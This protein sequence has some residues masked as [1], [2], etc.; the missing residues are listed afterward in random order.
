V[1]WQGTA[2]LWGRCYEFE[3]ILPYQPVAEALRSVVPALTRAELEGH[4]TWV[5]AEV[6]RLVPEILEKLPELD[7]IP[8]SASSKVLFAF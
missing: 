2:V 8:A 7:V 5:L 1:R 3:R 4:P 6:A